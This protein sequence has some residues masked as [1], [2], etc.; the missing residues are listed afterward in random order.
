MKSCMMYKIIIILNRG[1]A[2]IFI[3]RDQCFYKPTTY[4]I[5]LVTL[6]LTIYMVHKKVN[7]PSCA[8]S[9]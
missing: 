3:N 6:Q 7:L 2:S 5:I 1:A 8:S 9:W 4:W